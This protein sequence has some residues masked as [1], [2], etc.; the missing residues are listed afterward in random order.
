MDILLKTL[1]SF[2]AEIKVERS[3][4]EFNSLI[5]WNE[6]DSSLRFRDPIIMEYLV[7]EQIK[8][9]LI[10]LTAASLTK[11]KNVIQKEI[12]LNQHLLN[13]RA[14][15]NMTIQILCDAVKEEKISIDLL[16]SIIDLSRQEQKISDSLIPIAE[17][18]R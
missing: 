6:S 4:L 15:Q 3:V 5:R 18:A 1:I 10:R 17:K 16:Y 11:G 9:E 12:L 7:A 8:E 13:L 14:S 2:E